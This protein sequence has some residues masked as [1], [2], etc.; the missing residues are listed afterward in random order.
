M[1]AS[2]MFIKT[3]IPSQFIHIDMS[4]ENSVHLKEF[5]VKIVNSSFIN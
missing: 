4:E 2:L 5:K 1:C 3:M